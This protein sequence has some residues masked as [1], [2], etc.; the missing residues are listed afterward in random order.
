MPL[1]D[2]PEGA[3]EL[4]EGAIVAEACIPGSVLTVPGG[5]WPRDPRV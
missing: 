5:A 1:V 3:L 4:T 2:D